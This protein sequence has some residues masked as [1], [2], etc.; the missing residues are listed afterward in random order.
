MGDILYL[1]SY[2]QY[3][4]EN[5]PRLVPYLE[6]LQSGRMGV[7]DTLEFR[8]RMW[9]RWSRY[10]PKIAGHGMESRGRFM[11]AAA[12][13]IIGSVLRE[14]E[15]GY[16]STW[17]QDGEDGSLLNR[18]MI[19]FMRTWE[20]DRVTGFFVAAKQLKTGTIMVCYEPGRQ[21]PFGKVYL[22]K[23]HGRP[24]ASGLSLPKVVYTT[25]LPLYDCWAHGGGYRADFPGQIAIMSEALKKSLAEY[26]KNAIDT[27]NVCWRGP[28]AHLWQYPPPPFPAVVVA[29][30]EKIVLD[31]SEHEKI[32]PS[33]QTDRVETLTDEHWQLGRDLA[34]TCV[35][36]RKF[37]SGDHVSVLREALFHGE[38]NDGKV[39]I[40][41]NGSFV[42]SFMCQVDQDLMA[43]DEFYDPSYNLKELLAKLLSLTST[44]KL[45]LPLEIILDEYTVI[46][47]L[48]ELLNTCFA[49]KELEAPTLFWVSGIA[50]CHRLIRLWGLTLFLLSLAACTTNSRGTLRTQDLELIIV[51][52]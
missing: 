4:V 38:P 24:I 51:S 6:F 50:L 48:Q 29:N 47:P 41:T 36:E 40:K 32:L 25:L 34:T 45:S 16:Q 23:G 37:E 26:V 2:E 1:G 28:K 22:V 11:D 43:S 7:M 18:N 9:S 35:G 44:K 20:E 13:P 46:Q 5:Y 15:T 10:S 14:G 21:N 33:A 3:A 52:A 49:E 19:R 8:A 17:H 30:E 12:H 27:K 42:D 31:W 39:T